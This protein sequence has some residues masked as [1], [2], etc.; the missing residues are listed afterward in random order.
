MIIEKTGTV[1]A[2]ISGLYS[3]DKSLQEQ[4]ETSILTPAEV[5]KLQLLINK[6]P[7]TDIIDP[8]TADRPDMEDPADLKVMEL[9]ARGKVYRFISTLPPEGLAVLSSVMQDI[10]DRIMNSSVPGNE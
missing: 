7:K 2:K 6:L 5:S 3:L 10:L 4:I 9:N 8:E 1:V